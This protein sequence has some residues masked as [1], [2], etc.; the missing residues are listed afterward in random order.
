MKHPFRTCGTSETVP[1]PG[2]RPGKAAASNPPNRLSPQFTY[3][4][5]RGGS[6]SAIVARELGIPCLINTVDGSRKLRTGDPVTVDGGAGS[7]TVRL[8]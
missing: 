3:G 4:Y 1:G 7:V 2:W 8:R 5:L 6:H